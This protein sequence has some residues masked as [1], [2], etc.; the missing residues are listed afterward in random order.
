[1]KE[2]NENWKHIGDEIA[3][4]VHRVRRLSPGHRDPHR[5]HEEKSEIAHDL[6]ELARQVV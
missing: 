5:F 3:A 6:A 4:L 1:M 2:T